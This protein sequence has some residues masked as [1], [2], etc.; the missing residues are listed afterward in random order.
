MRVVLQPVPVT[1]AVTVR[2]P[3]ATT[4][5]TAVGTRTDL[6]VR[7]VPQA[8]TVVSRDIIADQT[9]R[10]MADVVAY[11]PGVGMAQ[12]EGHRD[13]PIF[14][15]NTST[16]DFFVDG[17][18]DD[19]QYL[20]DLYNVER[21]EVRWPNGSLTTTTFTDVVANYRIELREGETAPRY[22]R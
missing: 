8:I 15:G 10:S 9:M 18:R 19:T 17:L 22:L 6:P 21:I 13:A 14:R 12:G 2:A 5:R 7:D 4:V 1:E 20:R 3:A 16:S 11:V